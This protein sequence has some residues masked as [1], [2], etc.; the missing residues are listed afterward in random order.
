MSLPCQ[1]QN[2]VN[3]NKPKATIYYF[4]C[5]GKQR[6]NVFKSKK[7]GMLG[8]Y[9]ALIIT[10]ALLNFLIFFYKSEYYCIIGFFM[11]LITFIVSDWTLWNVSTTS[12]GYQENPTMTLDEFDS[13]ELV[14][15]I[16]NVEFNLKY[17]ETCHIKREI[18]TFHC[19]ECNLC[20]ERHDHHCGFI[21]NCVGKNNIHLFFLFLLSIWCHSLVLFSFC[22][23]FIYLL[24]HE[25]KG[26]DVVLLLFFAFLGL[27]SVGTCLGMTFI[28]I[29]YMIMFSYN[30]TQNE[31]IRK[32]YD[33]KVFDNGC[34]QNW[35]EVWGKEKEKEIPK[36]DNPVV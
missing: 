25:Q 26:I 30:Q 36:P 35:K 28:S 21:G 3:I 11:S 33:N 2:E 14:Q 19:S 9:A 15:T 8:S 5:C 4:F 13:S 12:P 24:F 17:C 6:I 32:K 22:A 34:K 18:R 1:K 7:F 10:T 23:Y 27:I 29:Q 20:I 16:R 31:Q